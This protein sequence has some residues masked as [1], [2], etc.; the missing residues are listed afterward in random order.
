MSLVSKYS[1]E[2]GAEIK[3]KEKRRTAN[4][5]KNYLKV[6]NSEFKIVFNVW[7]QIVLQRLNSLMKKMPMFKSD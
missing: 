6:Q 3:T 4:D 1:S 5:M 2:H 7:S